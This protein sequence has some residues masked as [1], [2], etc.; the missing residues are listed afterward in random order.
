MNTSRKDKGGGFGPRFSV[1][2][3]CVNLTLFFGISIQYKEAYNA[4]RNPRND[5]EIKKKS[6]TPCNQQIVSHNLVASLPI[7]VK[8]KLQQ[9]KKIPR[10]FLLFMLDS[11]D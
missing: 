9:R 10:I 1:R 8:Y 11:R 6:A 2:N 5:R 4:T 7:I 3:P